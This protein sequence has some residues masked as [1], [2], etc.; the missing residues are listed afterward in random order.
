MVKL[1]HPPHQKRGGLAEGK[2]L[3]RGTSQ[4]EEKKKKRAFLRLFLDTR[5]LP[6][7][8]LSCGIKTAARLSGSAAATH[9]QP[10]VYFCFPSGHRAKTQRFWLMRRLRNQQ[11]VT[12]ELGLFFNGEILRLRMQ[13]LKVGGLGKKNR[14][15]V[16]S[17]DY[18]A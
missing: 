4:K 18:L 5:G 3:A 7:S 17:S 13:P 11:L 15:G 16:R 8:H 14:S 2:A 9:L 1:Q 6:R 12:R 10:A